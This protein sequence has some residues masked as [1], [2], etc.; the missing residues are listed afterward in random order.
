MVWSNDVVW[1]V[2]C[3]GIR[4][5]EDTVDTTVLAR[6]KVLSAKAAATNAE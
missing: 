4:E 6:K 3:F 1:I 5:S 2:E